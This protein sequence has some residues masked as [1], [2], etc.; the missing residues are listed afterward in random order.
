MGVAIFFNTLLLIRLTFHLSH[1]AVSLRPVYLR[2][3]QFGLILSVLGSFIGAVIS[4]HKE[5]SF[6]A[7]DGGP[8]IPFF[9]W[10]TQAGGP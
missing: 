8:G 1:R 9:N 7:V 5:H 6:G 3:I 10:N 4:L 2:S